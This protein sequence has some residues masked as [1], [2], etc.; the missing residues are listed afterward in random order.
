MQGAGHLH[1]LLALANSIIFE[2]MEDTPGV[3]FHALYPSQT[4]QHIGKA[5]VDDTSLLFLKLGVMLMV[6]T[7][8]SHA[9]HCKAIGTPTIVCY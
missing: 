8:L 2:Q 1:A 4:A 5:F 3:E 6:I 9:D 7:A